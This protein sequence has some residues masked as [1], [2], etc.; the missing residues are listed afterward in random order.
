MSTEPV[1]VFDFEPLA[2]AK[3]ERSAFD[4]LAGGAEAEVTLRANRAAF[5]EIFLRPRYLVDVS[6]RELS[7]TVLG[8]PISFPVMLA[9]TAYQKLEHPEG[10]LASARA[11]GA[12]GTIMLV[13]TFATYSLEQIVSVATGPLWFQLYTYRDR[14]TTEWLIR[15]AEKAGYRVL[16]VTIDLPV[17]GRRELDIR[18]NFT[19]PEGMELKNLVGAGTEEL[20]KDV[21]GSALKAYDVLL[22]SGLTWRDIDWMRTVTSMPIVIKGILTAED[23]R[24]AAQHGAVGVVVSNHGGR[25]LD[26]A[27][28]TIEVL[29]EIVQEVGS[30]IEIY[31]DSGIRRGSDVLKA[32]ALGAR[33]VLVGRPFLWGLAAEGEVGVRRVLEILREELDTALALVGKRSV[34]EIDASILYP[35]K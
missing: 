34:A 7:T 20:P 23:A 15:R 35:L 17:V 11:A 13:S 22:E 9:P 12:A 25:Q 2:R 4:Y 33:A 30:E 8:T 21:D 18:N 1:N 24:L 10:E 32:L 16:C 29:P 5:E 3:M 31:L 6:Q 27:P 28:P 19:L 26:G 14:R